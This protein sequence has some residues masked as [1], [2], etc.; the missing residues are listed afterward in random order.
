MDGTALPDAA[1]RDHLDAV[2]SLMPNIGRSI[3]HERK[4]LKRLT[5]SI[6]K[7]TWTGVSGVP[8]EALCGSI[9][10]QRSC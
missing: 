4:L 8:Q 7:L 1:R 10:H 9:I 6:V 2:G 5:K 3:I